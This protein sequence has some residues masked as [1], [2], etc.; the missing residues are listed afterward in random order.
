MI[1]EYF[2]V[3]QRSIQA[4]SMFLILFNSDTCSPCIVVRVTNLPR[5]L[6]W[7][8]FNVGI[9][10]LFN[11]FAKTTFSFFTISD[12][13]LSLHST[14]SA[15]C[16]SFVAAHTPNWRFRPFRKFS[17]MS[18]VID[19]CDSELLLDHNQSLIDT[20]TYMLMTMYTCCHQ[21]IVSHIWCN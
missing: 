17:C 20:A 7:R 10:L 12:F 13:L 11:F 21:A 6:H 19:L 2:L 8:S 18:R 4:Y 3:F 5:Y 15:L 14:H 1:S 9:L 16:L